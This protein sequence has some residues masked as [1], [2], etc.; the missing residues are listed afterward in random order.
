MNSRA[1]RRLAL[2]IAA[3]FAFAALTF[4]PLYACDSKS[5]P[6]SSSNLE[7]V[8]ANALPTYPEPTEEAASEPIKL[9]KFTKSQAR[10]ARRTQSRKATLAQR[11]RASK[12][13][14]KQA[15]EEAPVRAKT[16]TVTPR[17]ANAKAELAAAD[18]PKFPDLKTPV[19][20]VSEQPKPAATEAQAARPRARKS[21]WSR[22]TNSMT[23][24]ARPGKPIRCRS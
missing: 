8:A 7:G 11:A 9:K 6:S 1:K 18:V 5:C 10:T 17:V 13:A 14:A 23:S 19:A 2:T 22:P 21:K 3:A 24:T 15:E 20:E 4:K 12:Y 16:A